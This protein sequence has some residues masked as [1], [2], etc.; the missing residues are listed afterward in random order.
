MCNPKGEGILFLK[1]KIS[2]K[3]YTCGNSSEKKGEF[4]EYED[5]RCQSVKISLY[6]PEAKKPTTFF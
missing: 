6:L 5:M 3:Y 2:N 4:P 1:F